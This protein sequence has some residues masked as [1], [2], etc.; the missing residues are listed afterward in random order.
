MGSG[1]TNSYT[2]G[3]NSV[4]KAIVLGGGAKLTMA[5]ATGGSSLFKV[6]GHIDVSSGGGS[7]LTLPA[8]T[9]HDIK[10]Y[11]SS[12]GGSILGAGTYTIDGY[13]ALGAN[14][15]GA[16]TCNGVSVG[17][18]ASNTTFVLSGS[19]TLTS[20]N[21]SG[22]AWC[23]T[24]G[25]SNVTLT[26]PTSGTFQKL[27]VIGPTG[28]TNGARFD[29]GASNV[30]LSGTFY[31]PNGPV[32]LGGSASVGNGTGQC[33]QLIGSRITLTGGTAAASAC[34]TTGGGGSGTTVV[35]VQ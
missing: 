18:T 31:F 21:C 32:Q 7:C 20:G 5:D 27:L 25:F 12:S 15:G 24:A 16:V 33:L 23:I 10:G 14:N 29:G 3:P 9:N 17:M 2:I 30:S 26:A 13:L 1:T 6:V 8:A 11:F 35:L 19:G 22:M 4:G 28:N 34:I